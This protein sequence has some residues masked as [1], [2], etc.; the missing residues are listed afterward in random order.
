VV[1]GVV[2]SPFVI[3]VTCPTCP[4]WRQALLCLEMMS[5]LLILCEIFDAAEDL[6]ANFKTFNSQAVRI[7]FDVKTF[8]L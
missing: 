4:F 8:V 7:T 6:N 2:G 3:D 5:F 1:G